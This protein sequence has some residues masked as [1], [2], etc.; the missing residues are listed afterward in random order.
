MNLWCRSGVC[1][2]SN[3]SMAAWGPTSWGVGVESFAE[4]SII[5]HEWL[6]P[7]VEHLVEL[8]HQRHDEDAIVLTI[9]R[10]SCA[11]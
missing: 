4:P 10:G 8:S 7:L 3:V 5:D 1:A 6:V 9:Q 2:H 11:L